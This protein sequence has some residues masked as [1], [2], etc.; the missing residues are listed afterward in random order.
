MQNTDRANIYPPS[1]LSW[2][3]GLA[4]IVAILDLPYGF[5]QLL[6]LVVT[7]YSAY[8][9]Y[10]Y[11]REGRTAPGWTFAFFA[12]IYNPV[13]IITMSKEVHAIFNI[14]T[15]AAVFVE[16]FKLRMATMEGR[17][18]AQF[19]GILI[20]KVGVVIILLTGI[21]WVVGEMLRN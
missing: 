10:I 3:V 6:R 17:E 5:Y 20:A 16:R 7:G 1:W 11:F 15:A 21:A 4:C 13:F 19:M 9:A 18:F 2:A 14:M 12:L 8:M